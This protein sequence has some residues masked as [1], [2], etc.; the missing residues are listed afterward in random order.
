MA[1]LAARLPDWLFGSHAKRRLLTLLLDRRSAGRRWS[2][3]ELADAVGTGRRG[4]IDEHLAVLVQLGL[5]RKLAKP[6]RYTAVAPA[7]MPPHL[8]KLRAG[9]LQVLSALE[10]VDDAELERRR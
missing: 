7:E 4:S 2:E 6:C 9:L 3:A 8:R 10:A 5:L 1:R